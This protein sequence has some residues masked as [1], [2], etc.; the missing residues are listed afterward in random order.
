MSR[1]SSALFVRACTTLADAEAAYAVMADVS[2]C[3]STGSLAM[4]ATSAAS[5]MRSSL[6]RDSTSKV[7]S[8]LAPGPCLLSDVCSSDASRGLAASAMRSTSE[9]VPTF[10]SAPRAASSSLWETPGLREPRLCSIA[11]LSMEK[12]S[13]SFATKARSSA[14]SASRPSSRRSTSARTL[15]LATAPHMLSAR[16][17]GAASTGRWA[18]AR[19]SVASAACTS[20]SFFCTASATLPLAP[21]RSRWNAASRSSASTGFLASTAWSA[22]SAASSSAS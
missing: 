19:R 9:Q 8:V 2:S 18:L 14:S 17:I 20:A 15:A 10:C 12:E 16:L 13:G 4:A 5:A 1:T 11:S 21:L 22:V 6:K 3:A 7:I